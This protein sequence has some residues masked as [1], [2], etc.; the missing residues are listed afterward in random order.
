VTVALIVA[1]SANDVI[2]HQGGL[3]WRLPQDLARFKSLTTGH[4]VIVGGSTQRSIVAQVGGPLPGRLTVVV[5]RRPP[6]VVPENVVYCTSLDDAMARAEHHR[7]AAGQAEVFIAGGAMVYHQTLP[8]AD[9]I[10]L[11]R[12]QQTVAGDT[13]LQAGWLQGFNLASAAPYNTSADGIT[14]TFLSYRRAP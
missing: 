6:A 14:Y 1:A 9:R 12:I 13:R 5:S 3:P 11:T 4:A 7:V 8:R 10:Y 2:G